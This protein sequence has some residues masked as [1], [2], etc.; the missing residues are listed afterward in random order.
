MD[1]K[2][3]A[4]KIRKEF[5]AKGKGGQNFGRV[6]VANSVTLA[7]RVR[8]D[9]LKAMAKHY[10]SDREIFS[11]S[12]LV[13]KP[14]L[15]VRSKSEGLRLGTYNFSDALTRYGENLTAEELGEAYKRAGSAFKGQLQ[16]NFVVL[17]EKG[18]SGASGSTG[19]NGAVSGACG[20]PRKRLR[21]GEVKNLLF[22]RGNK[23]KMVKKTE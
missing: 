17:N 4:T 12:A 1:S 14:V 22:D 18:V 13:S 6:F 3:L 11:V 21:E 2:E 15:H 16:Q 8:V 10:T 23:A 19:N 7:T 5:S 20:T 9:I